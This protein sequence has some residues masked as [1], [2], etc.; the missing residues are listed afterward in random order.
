MTARSFASHLS[1][2]LAAAALLG[3]GEAHALQPLQQ[4][5][6]SARTQS[7]DAIEATANVAAQDAQADVQFGKAL[8]GLQLRG[9]YTHNQ[10]DSIFTFTPSPGS[11]Q[12][13]VT[14]QPYDQFDAFGTI[15]VP[16]IDLAQWKRIAA[17]RRGAEQ[18]RKQLEAVQLQITGAVAQDYYQL[19]ADLAL[20]E[21]S[22]RQLA[23]SRQSLALAQDKFTLGSG[24]ELDV[25]RA[26]SDVERQVQQVASAELQVAVA[27]RALSSASGLAP[28]VSNSADFTADLHAE[29][30]L[31]ELEKSV[32]SLPQMQAAALA[33]ESA[34][35]TADAQKWTLAPALSGQFTEHLSNAPGFIGTDASYSFFIALTWNIDFTTLASIRAQNA[36]AEVARAHAL[37]QR[38]ASSDQISLEWNSVKAAIAKSRSARIEVETSKHAEE[39]A[40][41][42]YKVGA[43]TQLDLLQAQRDA[44]TAQ[45]SRIQA[46]ADL[47]NSRAQLRL[48]PA[49]CSTA[50]PPR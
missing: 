14:I 27:A 45:V 20:V 9:T 6:D 42:Q 16:L 5:L 49:S 12:I 21:A 37:R 13:T 33:L 28:D 47:A 23:V 11:P 17:A 19:V 41:E 18:T 38:L 35:A 30:P 44:F 40:T 1:P 8:P 10:Y 25:D 46:D 39:L 4:F 26:R 7:P 34:Q 29:G 32:E 48:R 15:N 3:A 22:Q 31:E 36:G 43:A 24:T 50:R 2:L